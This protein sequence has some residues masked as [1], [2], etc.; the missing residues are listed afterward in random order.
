MKKATEKKTVPFKFS[1]A[2]EK[3]DVVIIEV[4]HEDYAHELAMGILPEETLPPGQHKFIRG[5]FRKRYP[6]SDPATVKTTVYIRLGLDLEVL[7]Y[8]KQLA[9]DNNAESYQSVIQQVLQTAMEQGRQQPLPAQADVLL[10]NPQFIEAVAERVKRISSKKPAIKNVATADK[11]R[12]A[13]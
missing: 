4:S 13:A 9:K 12:R 6:D 2:E 10:D 11:R 5:G 7:D 1:V 3:G 8:F